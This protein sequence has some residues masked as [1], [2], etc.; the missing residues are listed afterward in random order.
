MPGERK[1]AATLMAHAD[2]HFRSVGKHKMVC[3]D[4]NI[5]SAQK[6][7]GIDADDRA[8]CAILWLLKDLGHNLR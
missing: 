1:D 4:D 8:G 2:T 7:V 3:K 6:G 5:R